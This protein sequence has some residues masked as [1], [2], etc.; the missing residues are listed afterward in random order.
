[1]GVKFTA[2]QLKKM[3]V[4][5]PGLPNDGKPKAKKKQ[6][7]KQPENPDYA[8]F[9]LLVKKDF[10]LEV[11]REH[12]FHPTREWRFDYA[13]IAHMIAIE[14]EGGIFT[15]GRHTRGAGF[16]EDMAKYNAATCLGW[17]LIRVTPEE[18]ISSR[19]F[20]MIE[21]LIKKTC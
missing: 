2:E 3:G 5:V 10:G 4:K 14:V 8:F 12:R 15:G 11:V 6:A 7:K 19:T 1:M 9:P 21:T 18:L 13:I 17:R 16:K 20:E